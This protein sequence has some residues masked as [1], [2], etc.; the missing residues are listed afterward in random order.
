MGHV[1]C[2]AA[3]AATERK[4]R[5]RKVTGKGWPDARNQQANDALQKVVF[6]AINGMSNANFTDAHEET[7]SA[8]LLR[9]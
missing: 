8:V 4:L 9:F 1:C 3:S 2:S 5:V 6:I 7:L